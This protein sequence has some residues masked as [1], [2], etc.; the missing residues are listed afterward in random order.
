[1]TASKKNLLTAFR[2]LLLASEI[3]YL[4]IK[5]HITVT[6]SFFLSSR[7]ATNTKKNLFH[8]IYTY[9]CPVWVYFAPS[10]STGYIGSR[11]VGQPSTIYLSNWFLQEENFRI[12]CICSSGT[13]ATRAKIYSNCFFLL[14]MS[15]KLFLGINIDNVSSP[16]IW[17]SSY[18]RW[19]QSRL[20]ASPQC[21]RFTNSCS[22]R[23]N[24]GEGRCR[25][26][27]LTQKFRLRC[28][29]TLCKHD[30]PHC[31]SAQQRSHFWVK[32][33]AHCSHSP[34]LICWRHVLFTQVHYGKY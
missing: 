22:Q 4:S 3:S 10:L 11:P 24:F 21:T 23:W 1:M 29:I 34:N 31:A 9:R 20:S 26:Y 32:G 12:T 16:Y 25:A 27:D 6:D 13:L 33:Y 7:T 17:A 18:T 2:G 15:P 8:D 14:H 30:V 19:Q 5:P 28:G